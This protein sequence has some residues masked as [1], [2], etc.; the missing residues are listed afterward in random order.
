MWDEHKVITQ[1]KSECYHLQSL[2]E[3]E[4]DAG[5]TKLTVVPFRKS[6]IYSATPFAHT[7]FPLNLSM[8]SHVH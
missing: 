7:F 2:I 3:G 1:M 5:Q 8:Y 6:W 4:K